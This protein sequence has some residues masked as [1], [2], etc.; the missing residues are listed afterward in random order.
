MS[1]HADAY[2]DSTFATLFDAWYDIQPPR[3]QQRVSKWLFVAADYH[4]VGTTTPD[5]AL[6][7]ARA[8]LWS[9]FLK[10]MKQF[11]GLLKG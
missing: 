4:M 1:N 7:M 8:M 6:D 3:I 10:D 9:L 2:H 11:L 5:T